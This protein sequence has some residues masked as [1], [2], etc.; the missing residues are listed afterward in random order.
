M[1]K[2]QYV[3]LITVYFYDTS[4]CQYIVSQCV[5]TKYKRLTL[6]DV[7]MYVILQSALAKNTLIP[8]NEKKLI[9]IISYKKRD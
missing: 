3:F 4:A 6:R 5:T 1:Y 8:V 2:K 9:S 7:R